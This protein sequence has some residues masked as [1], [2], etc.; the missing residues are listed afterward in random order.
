MENWFGF[1]SCHKDAA[2]RLM[3]AALTQCGGESGVAR[4]RAWTNSAM[5]NG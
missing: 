3:A 5:G 4:R 2:S 1:A